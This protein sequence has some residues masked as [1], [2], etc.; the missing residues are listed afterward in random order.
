MPR[1]SLQDKARAIGQLE[2]GVPGY[3]VAAAF[4]VS[5]ATISKLKTKFRE[6][7]DVKDRPR[8]GRPRKTTPQED[9]F[10]TLASL[11]NRRLPAR[12]LQARFSQ[13]FHRRISEQTVRNRLHIARL[14][15]H[16][17]CRK[18]AMTAIHRQ[19]HFVLWK[20]VIIQSAKQRKAINTIHLP[21]WQK[22][23]ERKPHV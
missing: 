10:L 20:R 9:R 18:T 2:A 16:K 4:G 12:A 21:F 19:A 14:H 15:S 11:R 6:T 7:G 1:L 13:R 17:A 8:S 22:K 3:R 5:P 23:M